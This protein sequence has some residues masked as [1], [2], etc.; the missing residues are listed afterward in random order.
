M[1][2]KRVISYEKGKAFAEKLGIGFLETSAKKSENVFQAFSAMTKEIIT[3]YQ[4]NKRNSF[5]RN[6]KINVKFVDST[7]DLK[8][9]K[10]SCSV[11]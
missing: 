3:N 11:I 4:A 2:N 6:N 10:C 5:N 1:E 7:E 8:D 9:P